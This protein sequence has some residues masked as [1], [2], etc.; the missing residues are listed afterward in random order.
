ANSTYCALHHPDPHSFPTRRSSD[1]SSIRVRHRGRHHNRRADHGED[2][3][4]MAFSSE[5]RGVSLMR[6]PDWVQEVLE[7]SLRKLPSLRNRSEEHT[8][9]LQSR[10]HLVCRL[11]LEKK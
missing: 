11:L 1:L 10:G 2:R 9:E 5:V 8:S 7:L 6:V 3:Q 4:Q